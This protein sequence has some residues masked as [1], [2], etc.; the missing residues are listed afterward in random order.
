MTAEQL[1]Q[2]IASEWGPLEQSERVKMIVVVRWQI[3]E[4][5]RGAYSRGFREAI[6]KAAKYIENRASIIRGDWNGPD[7]LNQTAHEIRAL[8]I[9]WK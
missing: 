8:K 9:D 2:H 6:E 7:I 3:E 5:E 1:A 4:S